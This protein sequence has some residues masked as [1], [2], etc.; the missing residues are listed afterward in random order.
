MSKKHKETAADSFENVEQALTKTE[1]FIED[2]QKTLTIVALALILIVGGYWG[3]KKLYFQPLEEEAA[4]SIF[5]AQNYFQRDS[6]KLA[7]N[8]DGN[9]LGF[10]DV[11][12]EYGSTKPGNLANY[13][14]GICYLHLGNYEDA[15][16]YLED[17]STDDEFLL[18]TKN[19][20]IGDAHLELGEKEEAL[21]YYKKAA[22][23][24]NDLTAP[25]YLMKLGMLYEDMGRKEDAVKAYSLIKKDYKNSPEA[26]QIDKY[27]TRASL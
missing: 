26:R 6:F 27:I 20:A 14:A 2:N 1:Q 16:N 22:G 7:L 11:I 21:K 5:E 12:D 15:I 23:F 10:L 17:F 24:S 3:L 13:Y 8:G 9:S 25:T 19:G 18:A 4:N